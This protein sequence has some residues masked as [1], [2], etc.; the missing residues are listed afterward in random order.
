M[1]LGFSLLTVSVLV[2]GCLGQ[3][4]DLE[5]S[6][7]SSDSSS[8]GSS[9]GSSSGVTPSSPT[10]QVASGSSSSSQYQNVDLVLVVDDN[11]EA[12]P[13]RARLKQAL[14][15]LGNS[16]LK[17]PSINTC[18]AVVLSSRIWF[19]YS[20]EFI[21]GCSKPA[22][23]EDLSQSQLDAQADAMIEATK[24]Y[25]PVAGQ[26]LKLPLA[27]A[28]LTFMFN[29]YTWESLKTAPSVT[30]RNFFRSNAL[31]HF[32]F[33]SHMNNWRQINPSTLIA[34]QENTGAW[35]IQERRIDLPMLQNDAFT[36]LG[37]SSLT[38]LLGWSPSWPLTDARKGYKQ[39]LDESLSALKGGQARYSVSLMMSPTDE[40]DYGLIGCQQGIS[41]R[42]Q[43]MKNLVAAV[44]NGSMEG[45]I[46]LLS[47]TS[48]E[49]FYNSLGLSMVNRAQMAP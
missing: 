39:Y 5:L 2:S 24:N 38:A 34:G 10:I 32:H 17:H 30:L 46:E 36:I 14:S 8:V 1:K 16:L 21:V 29:A 18:L 22:N 28:L 12:D 25:L 15:S 19:G 31:T 3:S 42:A 49:N 7:K 45:N 48:Y 33:F 47:G 40:N 44:Q 20:K 6:S 9:T 23:A 26:T 4:V 35:H 43:N 11:D 37:N 13:Y 41:N 27:K